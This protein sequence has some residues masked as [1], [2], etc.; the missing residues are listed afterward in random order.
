MP[1][2]YRSTLRSGIRTTSSMN[3]RNILLD[4]DEKIRR[5]DP[6]NTPLQSLLRYMGKGKE[7]RNYKLEQIKYYSSSNF[8][9]VAETAYAPSV[10]FSASNTDK[11]SRYIAV[12][13]SNISRPYAD[14]NDQL[15]H[16]QDSFHI[17]ATGQ[18]LEIVATATSGDCRASA[19]NSQGSVRDISFP[20]ELS[21]DA[22]KSGTYVGVT[23]PGWYLLRNIEPYPVIPF[24]RSDVVFLGRT[25]YESQ[26]IEAYPNQ[27]DVVYDCNYIERKEAVLIMTDEQKNMIKT[28]TGTPDFN[29][30]QEETVNEFKNTVEHVLMFGK[31]AVL[32]D[33]AGR[34]MH[35]TDGVLSVVRE[36]VSYYNPYTIDS[37]EDVVSSFMFQQAFKLPN[38]NKKVAL[39][40]DTFLYNFNQK[41][42]DFRRGESLNMTE[43]KVGINIDTYMIPGGYEL[44]LIAT[45][46]FK[47][48]TPMEHYCCVID[49]EEMEL[50][51]RI[52]YKTK[53]Y[54]LA[55]E[56]DYK[57][58]IEWQGGV[59]FNRT[60][61]FALLKPF[62][63]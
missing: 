30:Q 53:P 19:M 60:E 54:S 51:T 43:K 35:F 42:K 10:Q 34:P 9:Y 38:K 49:P 26:N 6:Q 45:P 23:L 37:L 47:R 4:I 59:A 57:L 17:V 14:A 21:G 28:A 20:V 31:K 56:R 46:F 11:S 50:R 52:D 44:K 18:R 40:G 7:P 55:H 12:R 25:I 48:N 63:S 1:G 32:Y 2:T 22:N 41:F 3:Q 58:M 16:A 62:R 33:V 8:D 24:D 13:M 61:S 36:N 15:Y 29:M 39:C 5:V 27:R